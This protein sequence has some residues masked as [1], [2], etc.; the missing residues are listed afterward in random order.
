[1]ANAVLPT[2]TPLPVEP[3]SPFPV[4]VLKEAASHR[5]GS[6][7]P[8]QITS[9][10]FDV[11]FITPVMIY[12]KQY[13]SELLKKRSQREG[14]RI[15]DVEG[16]RQRTLE[17]GNWSEYVSALPPV[18][19]VRVTPKLVESFWTTVARGAAQTQGVSLPP[20][21]HVTSGFSRMRAYCDEA[22]VTPIHPFKIEQRISER[23]AV[24]EGLYVFDPGAFG[25]QCA[26]VKFVLYSAK[27]PEKGDSRVVDPRVTQQIWQDFA[28]YRE[29][30][31]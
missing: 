30:G 27:S 16:P 7:N 10:A 20:I 24:D 25:P 29:L 21:K 17:F 15:V 3:A 26:M 1:M 19:L 23:D 14:S 2:G 5:A 28:P 9:S 13:Q 22:E 18:L 4:D 8:Y 31:R 6:L 12:G 11:S